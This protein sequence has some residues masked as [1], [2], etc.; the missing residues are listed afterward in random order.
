MFSAN[1]QALE[2]E[3]L[4][5][6]INSKYDEITPIILSDGKSMFFTRLGSPDFDKTLIHQGKNLFVEMDYADYLNLLRQNFLEILGGW[7]GDPLESPANQEIWTAELNGREAKVNHPAFPINNALP[8]SVLSATSDPNIFYVLNQYL[9]DGSMEKGISSVQKL[10]T[11]WSYPSPI[12]I[13]EFYTLTSEINV[14]VS[15]DGKYMLLSARRNDAQDLDIYL[16]SYQSA[17]KSWSK[18]QPIGSSLNSAFRE[19]AP[20]LSEDNSTLYFSS[21]RGGGLNDI[22]FSKRLDET[23]LRWS[24]PVKLESPINS[25]KNDGQACFNSTTGYLYFASDRSGDNDIYRV[26]LAPAQAVMINVKGRV[27]NEKTGRPL[28]G[29][30]ISY[31]DD[32]GETQSIESHDGNFMIKIPRGVKYRITA[33]KAAFS[34][35]QIEVYFKK[36]ARIFE[37]NY[38]AD[39]S[40]TPF[41]INEKIV[42]N[43][44]YF[45]QS[46]ADLLPISNKEVENL[47]KTLKEN[48]SMHILIEGHTDNLGRKADLEALSESRANTIKKALVASG[49]AEERLSIK[50]Y[51]GTRPVSNND[52]DGDRKK[53]RRVEIIITKI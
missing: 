9:P 43:P 2:I 32:K 12:Q 26:K 21:N 41:G 45:V 23:W 13:D 28:K 33:E 17:Q 10:G 29:V 36:E 52:N 14:T 25:E 8:N 53:N 1:G 44:F 6:S 24:E 22:Y 39:L 40:L 15:A 51:G 3:P 31:T 50:G 27:L 11:S 48:P 35:T 19:S 49:I 30:T 42:V 47:A 4:P 16:C 34:P 20:S 37:G 38:F 18:P 46:K 5:E 7:P